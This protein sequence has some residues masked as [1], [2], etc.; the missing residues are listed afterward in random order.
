MR[1]LAQ[2]RAGFALKET[3]SVLGNVD[4]DKFKSLAAG[5]PA[6]ILQNGLGQSLAFWVAKGK[7]EQMLLFKIITKWLKEEHKSSFGTCQHHADYLKKLTDIDQKK[8]LE[9][10][11]ETLALLEWVKRFAAADLE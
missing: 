11:N 4:R 5:A 7:D 9:A 6:M 2:K 3:L 10:Q 1:T 8:Y